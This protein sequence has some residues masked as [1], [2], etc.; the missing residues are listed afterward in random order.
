MALLGTGI[1]RR[2]RFGCP[3]FLSP[4][5]GIGVP[6]FAG[7]EMYLAGGNLRRSLV[8]IQYDLTPQA[9]SPYAQVTTPEGLSQE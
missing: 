1:T 7:V 9:D 8:T 2:S 4:W 3:V 5:F 6:V